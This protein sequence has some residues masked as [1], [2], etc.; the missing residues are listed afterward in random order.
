MNGQKI[1]RRIKYFFDEEKKVISFF[2]P[3]NEFPDEEL[4]EKYEKISLSKT[5][6]PHEVPISDKIVIVVNVRNRLGDFLSKAFNEFCLEKENC[7][8]IFTSYNSGLEPMEFMIIVSKENYL[9]IIKW[10]DKYSFILRR[11]S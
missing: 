4:S 6:L 11:L 2:K 7:D 1:T 3:I 9:R 5:D 10:L 8:A